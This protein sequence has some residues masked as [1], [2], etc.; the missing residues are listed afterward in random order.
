LTSHS[1]WSTSRPLRNLRWPP[2]R[3]ST[4]RA[5][6]STG[7]WLRSR[8]RSWLVSRSIRATNIGQYTIGG[9]I[10]PTMSNVTKIERCADGGDSRQRGLPAVQKI[11]EIRRRQRT[12]TARRVRSLQYRRTNTVY[13]LRGHCACRNT[14]GRQHSARLACSK[15]SLYQCARSSV[16]SQHVGSC[17]SRLTKALSKPAR[18][19]S[20]NSN[21]SHL[22]GAIASDAYRHPGMNAGLWNTN[23]I[24]SRKT[25]SCDTQRTDS[26]C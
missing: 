22:V 24:L 10:A 19:R 8:L 2:S 12:V 26:K 1:R 3:W 9:S 25:L 11:T 7:D 4:G 14:A 17:H 5:L 16:Y 6:R 18:R 23:L 21:L 15:V 13:S 20:T